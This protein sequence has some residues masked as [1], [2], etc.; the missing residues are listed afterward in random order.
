MPAGPDRT[1]A[2]PAMGKLRKSGPRVIAQHKGTLY[3]R[4]A[5]HAAL[6]LGGNGT[7]LTKAFGAD[8]RKC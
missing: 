1:P 3:G 5:P 6:A 8:Q 7:L 4:A 2:A